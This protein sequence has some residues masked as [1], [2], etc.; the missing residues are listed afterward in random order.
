MN[1]LPDKGAP[2][3]E[4]DK[5]TNNQI[6]DMDR[7]IPKAVRDK[8]RNKRIIRYGCIGVASSLSVCSSP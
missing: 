5:I 3:Q 6:V 7:E 1:P 2:K 4:N 8:E